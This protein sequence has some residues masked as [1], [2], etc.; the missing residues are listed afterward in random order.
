MPVLCFA[1][2]LWK[3][4]ELM[5]LLPAA[6][7]G[8]WLEDYGVQLRAAP[9]KTH[10]APLAGAQGQA[11]GIT[12][13]LRNT[14]KRQRGRAAGPGDARPAGQQESSAFKP[15]VDGRKKIGLGEV[16]G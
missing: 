5:L 10:A 6:L 4:D 11:T 14:T 12:R 7:A 8:P 2:W 3:A 15:E 9:S 13:G 16:R 1:S